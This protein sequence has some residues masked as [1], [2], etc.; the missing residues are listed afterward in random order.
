MIFPKKPILVTFDLG[1]LTFDL[2]F[3]GKTHGSAETSVSPSHL[4]CKVVTFDL[5]GFSKKKV[6]T[7]DLGMLTFDLGTSPFCRNRQILL[8]QRS[9]SIWRKNLNLDQW[10]TPC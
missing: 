9:T 7:F 1:M 6:L 10:S 5:G 3:F 2:G 4:P 8:D